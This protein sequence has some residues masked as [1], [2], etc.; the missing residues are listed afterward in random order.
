MIKIY[1]GIPSTGER[2]DAQIYSLRK[3]QER[4]KDKV[5][6]IYPEIFVGRIFHDYARNAYVEQFLKS[7]A[8]VLW[9]L[10][11]DV[12][13]P[14]D[15]LDAYI[16]NYDKWDCAGAPYPVF[17][18]PAGWDTPQVV[19]TVYKRNDTGMY[20]AS[21]PSEG[22]DYVDGVATGCIFI[23]RK[24]LEQLSKP[25]FEFKYNPE[26]RELVEGE[27]LGFCKKVSDLGYKFFID[28][29]KVCKHYKKV[30]LLDVNNY[31][32]QY[33]NNAI[34]AYDRGLRQ[35]LVKRKLNLSQPKS[36]IILP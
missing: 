14:S 18:T 33:S 11:S 23:K 36:R 30:C 20:T 32:I 22:L 8:D 26:T 34:L 5:T 19:F 27:D 13:P 25:Y 12:A 24:V 10:D 29:S 16:E 6:F 1:M 3:M 4:Y 21:V 31:A 17:M 7:D 35:S 28:Y 9:F 15:L 2:S